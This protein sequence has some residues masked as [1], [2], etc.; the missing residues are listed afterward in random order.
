[1]AHEQDGH[2]N[3][4]YDYDDDGR[5]QVSHIRLPGQMHMPNT[6]RP[7]AGRAAIALTVA[8]IEMECDYPGKIG[9]IA[10][11]PDSARI[12]AE[13]VR[14]LTAIADRAVPPARVALSEPAMRTG[15]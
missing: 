2:G 3:G 11:R 5:R 10:R 8:A 15:A 9:A 14:Y 12:R 6:A 7:S 13:S 1:M 4:A